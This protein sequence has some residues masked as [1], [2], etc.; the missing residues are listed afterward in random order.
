D[1]FIEVDA[2]TLAT[3]T[4]LVLITGT[5]GDN[6]LRIDPSAANANLAFLFDGLAGRDELDLSRYATS[7][8]TK[9]RAADA[10]GSTG[11]VAG[12]F[13]GVDSIVAPNVA[14]DRLE[15]DTGA[16]AATWTLSQNSSYSDGS[17]TLTFAGYETLRGGVGIDTMRVES[18]GLPSTGSL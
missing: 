4:E 16:P 15:D 5:A 7:L 12:V 9:L 11:S 18:F 17:H 13:L 6:T 8:T 2:V 14:G 3:G 10:E 1:P